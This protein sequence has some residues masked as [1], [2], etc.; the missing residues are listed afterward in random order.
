MQKV[1]AQQG[2]TSKTE[3]GFSGPSKGLGIPNQEVL[4]GYPCHD[5]ISKC[6]CN[7][8]GTGVLIVLMIGSQLM[9]L[10]SK[11]CSNFTLR[12]WYQSRMPSGLR[13]NNLPSLAA[14]VRQMVKQ[15]RLSSSAT[16]TICQKEF[17]SL[18]SLVC[19][20]HWYTLFEII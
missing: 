8:N 2:M 10:Q 3:I 17:I 7:H 19:L 9:Q 14:K 18:G 1:G 13:R 5:M 4:I 20:T 11:R 16:S 12:V 15:P 6:C